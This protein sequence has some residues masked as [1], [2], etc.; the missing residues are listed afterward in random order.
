MTSKSIF[1]AFVPAIALLALLL[2]SA[3]ARGRG[4]AAVFVGPALG[5]GWYDPFWGP[6][7]YG[8][9]GGVSNGTV[10]FDTGNKDAAV[11]VDGGYAGTVGKL[12]NLQLRPGA[13]NIE[14]RGAG[15]APY[16]QKVYVA[17]GKTVHVNP[18]VTPNQP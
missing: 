9:Y 4:G 17:A 8:S 16:T 15:A 5:F 3:S 13:Y 6:Y 1:K 2:P 14:V 10:K 7:P 12:K 11:F 18:G